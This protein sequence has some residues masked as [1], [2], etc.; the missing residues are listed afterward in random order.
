MRNEVP[1]GNAKNRKM[2]LSAGLGANNMR[3]PWKQKE[4]QT[5]IKR[6]KKR[7]EMKENLRSSLSQDL[8]E[9]ER[10]SIGCARKAR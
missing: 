3:S 10:L 9:A 2:K 5:E 7:S 4:K 6:V 1:Q 8:G